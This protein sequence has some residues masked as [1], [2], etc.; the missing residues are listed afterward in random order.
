MRQKVNLVGKLTHVNES[1]NIYILCCE[2][3]GIIPYIS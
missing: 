2:I 1:D 3:S